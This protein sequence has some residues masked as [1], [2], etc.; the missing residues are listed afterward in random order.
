MKGK[1]E[2]VKILTKTAKFPKLFKKI[3]LFYITLPNFSSL[4]HFLRKLE[5]GKIPENHNFHFWPFS[6]LIFQFRVIDD[7][8]PVK[9]IGG[10]R[11]KKTIFLLF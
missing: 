2:M 7:L 4:S 11:A 9:G 6:H 3:I 1:G 10:S 5:V 8:K